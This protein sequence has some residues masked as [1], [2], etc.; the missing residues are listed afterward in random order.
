M[1]NQTEKLRALLETTKAIT[2][3]LDLNKVL[4]IILQRG[5]ELTNADTGALLL[6]DKDQKLWTKKLVG[7]HKEDE[8]R[9]TIDEGITGWVARNKEPLL[10][11]DV[12]SDE[13]YI[14]WTPET[15]SE[16][17]VPML[18]GKKLIGVLNVERFQL[19][20]FEKSDCELL[21]AL[22][23]HA[24]IAI[25]NARLYEELNK[26][27]KI[28]ESLNKVGAKIT[29][30][31]EQ[32]PILREIAKG[33]NEIVEADIPLVY[34]YDQEKDEFP[35]IYYG[36]VSEEWTKC[37]PREGGAGVK[38][39]KEKKIVVVHED[40]EKPPGIS[41]FAKK[42]G[43]KTTIAVPMVFGDVATGAMYLHFLGEKHTLHDKEEKK[44][45]SL[46]KLTETLIKDTMEEIGFNPESK[47]KR[48]KLKDKI[49]E[50]IDKEE[51][52]EKIGDLTK[53]DILLVYICEGG[54]SRYKYLFST[55]A[56]LEDDL[57][58]S[59][60]PGKLRDILF[61]TKGFALSGNALVTKR[62]EN[63]WIITDEEEFM[64]RKEERKLSIYRITLMDIIFAGLSKEWR[65][66]C[67]P[68]KEG[69][70]KAAIERKGLVTAYENPEESYPIEGLDINPYPKQ[71]G[72]KTTAAYPLIFEDKTFGVFYMHFLERH[73]FTEEEKEAI[74]LLGAHAAIALERAKMYISLRELADVEKDVS[75]DLSLEER[76]SHV[77]GSLLSTW[78]SDWGVLDKRG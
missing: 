5:K 62:K 3:E 52:A 12:S 33:L 27:V 44:L 15:K 29:A 7:S 78:Y 9:H 16:L 51:I 1:Q 55:D 42:K 71:K 77:W 40:D 37:V 22:A 8:Y 38:A 11:P 72:S 68:R 21:A 19:G 50:K 46:A 57:N 2:S 47:K 63:E 24:A 35:K 65:A 53:A 67:R 45:W 10:V 64:V 30:N 4:N 6:V 73:E 56:K 26:Q 60:I 76:L 74:R 17:A 58:K 34:L 28:V 70:G 66:N 59:I 13:R 69:A 31:I 41:T 18:Y 43:V 75:S 36:D 32:I 48:A 54:E 49:T 20:A 25:E 61:E 14:E 23:G 39:I